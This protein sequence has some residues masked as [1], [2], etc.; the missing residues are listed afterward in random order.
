MAAIA[1]EEGA[2]FHGKGFVQDVAFDMAGGGELHLAGA[3]A[4]DHAAAHGNV[5]RQDLAVNFRLL[6]DHKTNAANI[7]FDHAVNLDIAIRHQ[8]AGDGQIGADDGGRGAAGGAALG[9]RHGGEGQ[10][11]GGCGILG[12]REHGDLPL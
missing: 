10:G 6:A 7:A 12:F 9:R 11:C 4:A 5:F 1:F 8:G 2:G 3:D